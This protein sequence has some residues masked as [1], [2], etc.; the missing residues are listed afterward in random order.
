MTSNQLSFKRE[1]HLEVFFESTPDQIL[2]PDL[3]ATLNHYR[4]FQASMA[5]KPRMSVRSISSLPRFSSPPAGYR[6]GV[7]T[8]GSGKQKGYSCPAEI[9]Q[10]H[11]RFVNE[12]SGT[13]GFGE[14]WEAE[15]GPTERPDTYRKDSSGLI[16]TFFIKGKG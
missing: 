15:A 12:P 9:S 13:C 7:E 4:F 16:Y 1:L 14:A 8:R 5:I 10:V 6:I 3:K 11:G 2:R